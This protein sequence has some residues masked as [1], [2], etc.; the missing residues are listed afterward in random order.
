LN[1]LAEGNLDDAAVE[2]RRFQVMRDYLAS[3][4][5]KAE[6]PATLG[7]YLSGFVFERRGEGD[8]ALRY[9]EE[10][11]AAG[12]LES[13]AAPISRLARANPYRGP[14][15]TAVLAEQKGANDVAPPPGELLVVLNVGRVPHKQPSR[16]PVGL[17]VSLAGTWASGNVDWLK[18]GAGKVVVYPEL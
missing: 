8:R 3:L 7:T 18:Y 6:G 1:Y 12:R 16:I 10:A 17:A 9:Y 2:A 4:D 15:V 11:L 5:I 13:L 14:H